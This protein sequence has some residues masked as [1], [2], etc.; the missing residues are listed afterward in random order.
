MRGQQNAPVAI[1]A[2]QR[3]IY[4]V[5]DD[6]SVRTGLARLMRSAGLQPRAYA[7]ASRFLEEVRAEPAACIL[8]DITMRWTQST[9]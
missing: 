8:L 9:G 3:V 4:I 5:D 1:T 6:E 7:M 2:T